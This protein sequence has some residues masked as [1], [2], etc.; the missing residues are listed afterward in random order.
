MFIVS[1]LILFSL[2]NFDKMNVKMGAMI[3]LEGVDLSSPYGPL[4]PHLFFIKQHILDGMIEKAAE[5]EEIFKFSKFG[6]ALLQL[7]K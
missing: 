7:Q 1:V 4:G 3:A 5:N 2:N 6:E